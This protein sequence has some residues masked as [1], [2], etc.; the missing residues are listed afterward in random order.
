M[1]CLRL[2]Q[3]RP[4][5]VGG[6][7]VDVDFHHHSRL[8][9]AASLRDIDKYLDALGDLG[10]RAGVI[11][12][13]QQGKLA[14]R[15]IPDPADRAFDVEIGIGINF[16]PYGLT[17]RQAADGRGGTPTPAVGAWAL[18]RPSLR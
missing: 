18:A 2:P 4:E 3:P 17:G 10:K 11:E 5:S 15:C 12:A 14:G 7:V 1:N 13:R 9:P 6:A 16:D 8:Q